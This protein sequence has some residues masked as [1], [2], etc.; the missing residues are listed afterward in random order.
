[1][2]VEKFSGGRLL[3]ILVFILCFASMAGCAENVSS[4]PRAN[5]TT[6]SLAISP[7]AIASCR[8][9]SG[10]ITTEP[11]SGST[12]EIV[13]HLPEH[14]SSL[15]GR[16]ISEFLFDFNGCVSSEN[17]LTLGD[18]KSAVVFSLYPNVNAKQILYLVDQLVKSLIFSQVDVQKVS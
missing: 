6:T 11:S 16:Y 17:D 3:Y 10:F 13:A 12:S 15:T 9:P 5:D 4:N 2:T 18:G 14:A 8:G 1:M 7:V